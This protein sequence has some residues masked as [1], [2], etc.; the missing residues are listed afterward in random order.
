MPAYKKAVRFGA[1]DHPTCSKCKDLMRLTRR[2]PHPIH[3]IE[4]EQQTFECRSCGHE[5]ERN[6]DR[7]GEIPERSPP[8]LWLPDESYEGL[9]RALKLIEEEDRWID[10]FVKHLNYVI[11]GVHTRKLK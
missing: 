10:N 5:V 2:A 4:F 1:N 8:T 7:L 11:E 9:D 6:A 3:G